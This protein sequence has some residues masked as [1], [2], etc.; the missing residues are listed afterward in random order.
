MTTNTEYK[1]R[2]E[3]ELSSM[4][5]RW[6]WLLAFG[7]MLA[8]VGIVALGATVTATLTTVVFLGALLFAG[9]IVDA[10]SSIASHGW[11]GAGV[12][13]LGGVLAATVGVMLL[14]RPDVGAGVLTLLLAVLLL[15][16]GIGRMA[17]SAAERYPGWGWSFVSGFLA[18]VLGGLVFAQ[19]P[20]S[21]FWFLGLVVA[22]E[23]LFR[24]VTW[25]GLAIA[26]RRIG[27]PIEAHAAA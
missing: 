23:L 5:P 24:G 7:I 1:A 3:P 4:R 27:E 11:R 14:A 22:V 18:V 21:A 19:F 2:G 8:L 25:I 16:N 20:T 15:A 17:H 9:G 6:G 26:A 13:L 10:V 12:A